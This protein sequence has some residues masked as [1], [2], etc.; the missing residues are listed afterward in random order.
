[1]GWLG[2]TFLE[3]WEIGKKGYKKESKKGKKDKRERGKGLVLCESL[4][5]IKTLVWTASR[6]TL[7]NL[8][9]QFMEKVRGDR[10]VR[11]GHP[12]SHRPYLMS[13]QLWPGNTHI[14]YLLYRAT[15]R[16]WF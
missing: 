1:M 16:C 7:K 13:S 6:P 14:P 12:L 10:G 4:V 5:A 11:A 9:V 8:G 15:G 3:G 2:A